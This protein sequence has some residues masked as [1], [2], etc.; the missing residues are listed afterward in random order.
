[1][2]KQRPRGQHASRTECGSREPINVIELAPRRAEPKRYLRA[3]VACK[4]LICLRNVRAL[5]FVASDASNERQACKQRWT[6]SSYGTN[7]SGITRTHQGW[8]YELSRKCVNRRG[9]IDSD[10]RDIDILV[11]GAEHAQ[12]TSLH[13]HARVSGFTQWVRHDSDGHPAS[14]RSLRVQ[15]A[16]L[17]MGGADDGDCTGG[18]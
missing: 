15:P 5:R 9:P 3:R 6:G 11:P 2:R 10:V 17:F 4:N 14:A 1:M 16:T 13:I 18:C 7:D 12:L 8:T